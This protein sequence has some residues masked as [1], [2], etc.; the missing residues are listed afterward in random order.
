MRSMILSSSAPGKDLL[1]LFH[2]EV[3]I[4]LDRDEDAY[5]ESEPLIMCIYDAKV[6]ATKLEEV[7]GLKEATQLAG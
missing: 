4:M 6:R 5:G 7:D 2:I 3:E 1:W